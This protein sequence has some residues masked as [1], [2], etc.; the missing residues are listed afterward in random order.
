MKLKETTAGVFVV[1]SEYMFRNQANVDELVVTLM[2][3]M[4]GGVWP[5][6]THRLMRARQLSSGL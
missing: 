4:K 2:K 6:G 5:F 3:Y 1:R